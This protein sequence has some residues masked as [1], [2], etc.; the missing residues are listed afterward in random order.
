MT[1]DE[2][3]AIRERA[4]RA[5]GVRPNREYLCPNCQTPWKCNG[6]HIPDPDYDD[7]RD[8]FGAHALQDVR[9]LLAELDRLR[10]EH[11]DWTPAAHAARHTAAALLEEEG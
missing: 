5:T 3:A 9:A 2:L 4:K 10:A 7:S 1:P 11:A 8:V 6:P